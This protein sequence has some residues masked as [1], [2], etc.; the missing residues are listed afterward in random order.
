MYSRVVFAVQLAVQLKGDLQVTR[1]TLHDP[2]IKLEQVVFPGAIGHHPVGPAHSGVVGQALAVVHMKAG[3]CIAQRFKAAKHQQPG[4]SGPLSACGPVFAQ[5]T[6]LGQQRRFIQ[7]QPRMVR[8]PRS[9]TVAVLPDRVGVKVR[10]TEML[11]HL[12]IG[13]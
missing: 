5:G 2:Q 11:D 7:Q 9:K 4:Y 10:Q 13:G 6:Q 8:R 12:R 1:Q 3:Q